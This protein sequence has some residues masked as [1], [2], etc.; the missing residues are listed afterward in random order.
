MKRIESYITEKLK[1]D[2]KVNSSMFK[3]PI[4]KIVQMGQLDSAKIGIEGNRKFREDIQKQW[5]DKYNITDVECI[6]RDFV[7]KEYDWFFKNFEGEYKVDN[8]LCTKLN[9]EKSYMIVDDDDQ[10]QMYVCKVNDDAKY[11]A[12]KVGSYNY[13]TNFHIIFYAK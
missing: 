3:S 6:M 10:I 9:N 1:I 11:N 5:I 12:I 13:K 4:D 7:A 2:K 8:Y